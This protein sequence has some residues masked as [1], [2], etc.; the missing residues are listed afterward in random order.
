MTWRHCL[1]DY[2]ADAYENP[3][4]ST[5]GFNSC[6][7]RERA[8]LEGFAEAGRG[9]AAGLPPFCNPNPRIRR[10]TK[11]PKHSQEASSYLPK[12]VRGKHF[13]AYWQICVAL[14]CKQCVASPQGEMFE[15]DE[16]PET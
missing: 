5:L 13:D 7:G 15:V 12:G 1:A 4:R 2:N 14:G 11:K 16:A 3:Y 8:A 10:I 6:I 9:A